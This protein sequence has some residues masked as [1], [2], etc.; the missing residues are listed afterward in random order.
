MAMLEL[1]RSNDPITLSRVEAALDEVSIP[2]FRFDQHTALAEGS[3][4]AIQQRVMVLDEDFQAARRV[5]L[6]LP[7]LPLDG[8]ARP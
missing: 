3:I 6:D 8:L 2:C 7:G 1:I 4:G 5:L